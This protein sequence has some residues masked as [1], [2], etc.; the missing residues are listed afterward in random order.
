LDGSGKNGVNSEEEEVVITGSG[1]GGLSISGRR[2][3]F[4]G[5]ESGGH[6]FKAV[7]RGA[8]F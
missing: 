1:V 3:S 4:H 6:S 8:I 5:T 2:R 7:A